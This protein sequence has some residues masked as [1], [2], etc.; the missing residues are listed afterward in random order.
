[1]APRTGKTVKKAK[2][3][4][5]K[6]T[7]SVTATVKSLKAQVK[8]LTKVSYDKVEVKADIATNQNLSSPLNSYNISKTFYNSSAVWGYNAAD[9]AD[10]N[11]AY[12]NKKNVFVSVR[13]NNEPNLIR[14]TM[15]LVSLKDQGA[16]STTFDPATG[17]LTLAAGTHYTYLGL[18]QARVSPRFFNIHAVRHFTMGYEG[19]AGPTADTRSERRFRFQIVP[20]QRLVQNPKGNMFANSDFLFPKDPSQNYFVILFNDNSSADLENNRV[21]ISVSDNWAIP[22]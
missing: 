18:D 13:Q 22:S 17:N 21:D 4:K 2:T 11:K 20:K 7:K 19:T 16:D 3:T 10:V 1:M 6:T 5:P 14:Y 8:K 12:M 15:F 9:L